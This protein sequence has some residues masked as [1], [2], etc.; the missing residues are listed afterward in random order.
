[1]IAHSSLALAAI[2]A[3]Q[4][5]GALLRKGF[6]SRFATTEKGGGI[7]NTVTEYDSAAEKLILEFLEQEVPGSSFLAEESGASPAASP[8]LWIVDP[9]DGT[10]NFAH[11]IPMFSVSIAAAVNGE[12]VA[13]VV[14]QP[15]LNELFFAEKGKGAYLNGQSLRVSDIAS[16]EKAI[17]STGFP[18]N[19]AENPLGCIDAFAK[20]AGTGVPLRRLGSAAIDL[21]YVAAGRFEA[22]WEVILQPWD[23][24]AGKLIIEEA[25]GTVT[26]YTGQTI[27]PLLP[28]PV[29]ASNGHLH[30]TILSL[31]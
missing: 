18:Y 29:I 7:Q 22:H 12:V 11:G 2:E 19:V 4:A 17:L 30:Q 14:Y 21:C 8:I 31:V 6:G 3:A 5:A 25:G 27:N 1:M 28:S 23:M 26:N 16:I 9:L 20:I 15:L 24:A 10:V 13:G